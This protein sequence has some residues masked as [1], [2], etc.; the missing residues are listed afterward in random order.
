[1]KIHCLK[2]KSGENTSH[3]FTFEVEKGSSIARFD[4]SE[5][6]VKKTVKDVSKSGLWEMSEEISSGLKAVKKNGKWGFADASDNI[7][8][9][10]MYEKVFSFKEGY[11]ITA[12]KLGGKV[13]YINKFNK[14]V[15]P[16]KYQYI[17]KIMGDMIRV[18]E[19][20]LYGFYNAKCELIYEPQFKSASD[21]REGA[22]VVYTSVVSPT[23]DK[24]RITKT[25]KITYKSTLK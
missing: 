1:M 16:I 22:D 10:T 7:V 19:N 11:D 4:L 5:K 13:G 12:V 17:T 14:Q 21:F 20:D 23:G 18:K 24:G 6:T 3:M 15:I 8:I 2:N 9:P 25:G